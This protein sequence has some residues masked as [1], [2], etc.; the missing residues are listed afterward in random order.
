MICRSAGY[1]QIAERV[2]GAFVPAVVAVAI[3]TFGAWTL[4]RPEPR[5]AY[6]LLAAVHC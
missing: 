3:V 2:C 1:L 4:W 6:A 5:L